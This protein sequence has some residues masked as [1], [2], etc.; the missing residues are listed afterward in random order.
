[1]LSG[2]IP[3]VTNISLSRRTAFCVKINMSAD[4]FADALGMIQGEYLGI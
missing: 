1:M 2:V 4:T 3:G